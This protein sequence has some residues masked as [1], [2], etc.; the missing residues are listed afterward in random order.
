MKGRH[1]LVTVVLTLLI[2]LMVWGLTVE[3]EKKYGKEIYL[4]IVGS[5]RINSDPYISLYLPNIK[6]RLE[7]ASTL[8]FPITLTVIDSS[9]VNAFATIGGYIYVTTGL[10][11]LCDTEEELAGVLSHELAHITRRH[12]QKR[13]EKEKYLNIGMLATMLAAALVGDP[14]L[15]TMGMA[16]AQAVSLKY[17]RDD[18]E[19]ADRVGAVVADRAGYNAMGIAGF[20]KKLRTAG[21]EATFPEYLL[22]HPIHENRISNIETAW[23]GSKTTVNTAF[24]PYLLVRATVLHRSAG[25]GAKEIW[26]NKYAKDPDDPM[27]AYGASLVQMAAGNIE[28]SARIVGTI[29][30]PYRALL[31]AEILINGRKFKEAIETLKDHQ[32]PIQKYFLA[33]A[34]EGQGEGEKALAI[35]RSLVPYGPAYPQIYYRL[36]MIAGRTGNEAEGYAYLGRY[37]LETGNYELAKTNLEKAISKFGIN[38]S[39]AKDLL[40]ILDEMKK[41]R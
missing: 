15:M 34:Y 2:P 16:S 17:S 38:S 32:D 21:G 30:S 27:A 14:T 3:E 25:S 39:E 26:L 41:Q 28:E 6:S 12:V 35:L 7:N 19:D 5:T 37:Y 24:F 4:Q 23:R 8:P 9:T 20:L 33:A 22:T 31:T 1:L 40:R 10:V 36:G 11:A 13:M 18:E 29:R